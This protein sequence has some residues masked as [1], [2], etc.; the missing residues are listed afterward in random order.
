MGSSDATR[1]AW[2]EWAQRELAFYGDSRK[3]AVDAAVAAIDSHLH[4]TA[5][6]VAARLA[7]GAPVP[8][9]EIRTL[10]DELQLV[11]RITADLASV[12]PSGALTAAGPRRPVGPSQAPQPP[13]ARRRPGPPR[14]SPHRKTPPLTP[15]PLSPS[16]P[17]SS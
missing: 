10:W 2:E 15:P 4:S 14:V 6:V 5:A 8:P 9:N 3:V 7:A 16:Y 1:T 17:P 12:K 11:D 13:Q